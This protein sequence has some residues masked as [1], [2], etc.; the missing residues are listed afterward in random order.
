MHLNVQSILPKLDIIKCESIAYDILV[1]TE[2]W[3][4]PDT[5]NE[6]LII[7]NFKSPF[8]KDR[9][10]RPGGGVLIYTRDSI[11][12]KRRTDLEMQ[13]LEAVWVEIT[14]KSKKILIGGFY[15]PPHSNTDYFNKINESIDRAYSTNIVDILITGDFNFNMFSNE[16]NK[17]KELIQQYTL[18]QLIRE[19]THFT[20]HSASLIDLILV[21]NTTSIVTSGVADSFIP[22]QIRF[23]CPVL[24]LLKFLRPT[25]KSY[26]ITTC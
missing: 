21:R 18:N 1:F 22:D 4:K 3:L 19:P 13:D 15:R 10:D 17:M 6:K 25:V 5:P 24:V 2:S 12:S 7:D 26:G 11:Q 8:R 9:C 23:H 20:E 16:N 14:I